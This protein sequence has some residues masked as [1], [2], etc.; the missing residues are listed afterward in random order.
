MRITIGKRTFDLIDRYAEG[1]RL[2][3]GEAEAL[4]KLVVQRVKAKLP[5]NFDKLTECHAMLAH[6]I[7]EYTFGSEE[8]FALRAEAMIIAKRMVKDALKAQGKKVA[9]FSRASISKEANALYVAK[10]AELLAMASER[11]SKL[12]AG[13]AS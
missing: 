2:T 1:H 7:E 12:R 5:E 3:A 11:L 6:A 4:S 8:R 10:E 9:H 13:G